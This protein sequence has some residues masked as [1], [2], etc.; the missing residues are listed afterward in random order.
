MKHLFKNV[1]LLVISLLAAQPVLSSLNCVAGMVSACA[2]GCPMAMSNMAPDCPMTGLSAAKGCQ[3]NCCTQNAINAVLPRTAPEKSKASIH[4]QV[5][6]IA[7]V[8]AASGLE[9][10]AAASLDARADSPPQ[11]ILNRVFRI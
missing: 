3:Q 5:A 4:V 10:Q 11:Y 9:K 7:S 2:P 1:V 6:L 8:Y